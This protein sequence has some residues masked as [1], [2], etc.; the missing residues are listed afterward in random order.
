MKSSKSEWNKH[1]CFFFVGGGVEG[2][3]T[4]ALFVSASGSF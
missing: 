4:M 1:M 2:K 3:H